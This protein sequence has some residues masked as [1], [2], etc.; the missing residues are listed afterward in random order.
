[1]NIDNNFISNIKDRAN[2]VDIVGDYVT[3]KNNGTNYKACCPFHHENTPS[4]VVSENKQIFKCFGCGKS[5]DAIKFI[6]FIENV[7]FIEA[8]KILA[9][10]LNME[11]PQTENGIN[12]SAN[13]VN[14]ILKEI[15]TLAAR[16][17]Y[18]KLVNS[19]NAIEYLKERDISPDMIKEFG[20]GYSDNNADELIKV[21]KEKFSQKQLIDSGIVVGKN[22]G[23][24]L[25]FRNRIMFPIFDS[26]NKVIAFGGRQL[27]NYGPKYLNSPETNIFSKKENLYAFN[28][29]RKNIVNN[30]IFLVEGYMDVIK[31]HQYGYRNT[32][33]SLGT[34]LTVEQAKLM[35][36]VASRLFIIYD[37][38]DAGIQ[39]SLRALDISIKEGLESRVVTILNA[40]DPDEYL[41]K[42]GK[43]SFEELL[44]QSDD[45]LMFNIKNIKGKYKIDLDSEK[46]DF[47][48]ES[49]EYIKEYLSRPNS[50]HIHVEKT[51]YYMAS[52]SGYSL[53]S[54][55]QDIFG[56]YFSMKQFSGKNDSSDEK[57]SNSE[58]INLNMDYL[59]IDKKEKTLLANII[60][61]KIDISYFTIS[62]FFIRE[63]RYI[64]AKIL[65]NELEDIADVKE[66]YLEIEFDDFP[67]IRKN[68]KN[69]KLERLIEH[70]EKKQVELLKNE[71][72]DEL[73]SALLIGQHIINLNNNKNK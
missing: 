58:D 15:N 40:K 51:M 21:L 27:D 63:N 66:Y 48:K 39:A 28:I 65:L 13:S 23:I 25:R 19:K 70:F 14:N 16:F 52:T 11:I 72:D 1:M 17:Y 43:S 55:G 38:D 68:M 29:A 24:Y 59:D 2:I 54:I 32:V 36:K 34:S 60:M 18:K 64:Y 37:S 30:S 3:L 73:K 47:L 69:I 67:L 57:K 61:G 35:K 45:Y 33:A 41:S 6:E 22:D 44:S 46:A 42:Y 62:D 10:K 12:F 50:S 5:G 4:F 56:K 26:R 31:M 20:L 49:V 7:D 9:E 53:K 71:G 8:V